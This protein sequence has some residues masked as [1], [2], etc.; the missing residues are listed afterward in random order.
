MFAELGIWEPIV[1]ATRMFGARG[2]VPESSPYVGLTLRKIDAA[3]NWKDAGDALKQLHLNLYNDV[4]VIP[5]WQITEHFAYRKWLTGPKPQS[6]TFY[7]NVERWQ[8][9]F[10]RGSEE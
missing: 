7:Q 10:R 9:G 1:D 4:S 2:Y 8:I 6:V 5:L 3:K